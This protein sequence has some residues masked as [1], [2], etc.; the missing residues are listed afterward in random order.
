MIDILLNSLAI[1]MFYI[2]FF[3]IIT[4]IV[5]NISAK[6]KY[7]SQILQFFDNMLK[8]P[9][10]FIPFGIY[11]TY[12]ILKMQVDNISRDTTFKIV[13]RG[14]VL[15]NKTIAEYQ[16]KC[17]FFINTIY[18]DWQKKQM[19]KYF[20]NKNHI[21]NDD[22]SAVNYL[23]ILMFQSWEDFLTS[24]AVDQTGSVVWIANYVQWAKSKQLKNI[25]NVMKPNF[26]HTTQLLGDFLFSQAQTYEP[27]NADELQLFAKR[28]DESEEFQKIKKIR[29]DM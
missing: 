24:L 5:W 25:W 22:W 21:N 13:D 20:I 27:K 10:I 23:S 7:K 3:V 26:A 28:C 18:Y 12:N 11:L 17:P 16:D 2:I 6:Y 19:G 15:I 1:E 14:W 29:M 8:I 9:S 4:Y